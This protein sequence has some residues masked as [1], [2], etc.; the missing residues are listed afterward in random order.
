MTAEDIVVP[1]AL[2]AAQVRFRGDAGRAWVD[3]VAGTAAEFLDRWQLRRDGAPRHGVAGLVLPVVTEDGTPAMLKL[4]DTDWDHPGE[5]LALRTW[6]GDGAARLLREDPETWTLLLERLDPS[7]DLRSVEDDTAAVRVIASLLNRL[8]AVPAPPS[9]PLLSDKA[10][11]MIS[12]APAAAALLT[13]PAEGKL[14]QRWADQLAEVVGEAGDRLLH[15]DL[16]YENVLAGGR[17][18]WLAIDP[19]PLAGDPGFELC[20]AL[21]NR[22]DR[23]APERTIR[24]RFDVMVEAMGLDR[25]RA[26]VWTLGRTLQNSIWS[27]EDGDRA[28]EP[29]MVVVA[30]ALTRG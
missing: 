25:Q 26:V 8:N 19:K 11:Q 14:I 21:W 4:Q 12:D 29:E 13:D 5:G 7:V 30:A 23:T 3:G 9:I 10:A 2:V 1:P 24:R 6:N 16:H 18:P 15:W 22:W 27:V 28:L 20:P 17:E